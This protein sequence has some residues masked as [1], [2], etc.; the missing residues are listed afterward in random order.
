[1]R[2]FNIFVV[3]AV[4]SAGQKSADDID[5]GELKFYDFLWFRKFPELG[6]LALDVKLIVK[7]LCNSGNTFLF[8]QKN[9]RYHDSG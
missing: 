1:M 7:Y 9:D 4:V 5:A 8:E 3:A 6:T 2:L